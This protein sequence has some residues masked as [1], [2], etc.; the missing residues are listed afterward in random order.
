MRTLKENIIDRI[1]KEG[2]MSFRSFMDTCLYDPEWGYYNARQERIGKQ[3]DFYTSPCI[4]PLFGEMVARQIEECWALMGKPPFTIVEY[5]AGPGHLCRDILIALKPNDAL[6]SGLRYC[7]IEQSAGMQKAEKELLPEKVSWHSGILDIPDLQG[8]V[9]SN[10]LLDNFPVHQVVMQQELM[11]VF[12]DYREPEEFAE[13]LRPASPQLKEYFR[14]LEVSLPLGFRTEVNLQMIPWIRDI[15]RALQRGF[16]ITIDYGSYSSALY[17][18][19]RRQGTLLCYHRHTINDNPYARPGEQDITAHVNF[20]ALNRWGERFGL[21]SLGLTSQFR[22]LQG[23]GLAARLRELAVDRQKHAAAAFL[24]DLSARIKV[25]V[26]QKGLGLC[27]LS[28][29][30]FARYQA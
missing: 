16:L 10:E 17:D 29:L 13:L 5:G 3:G 18:E 11:E 30:Q 7:I 9:L 27:P 25:F 12:V 24:M 1:R 2:P 23:L 22:F 26:Q 4:S 19:K 6:Y 28:G 15:A 14:G 20:S 8:C 21:S